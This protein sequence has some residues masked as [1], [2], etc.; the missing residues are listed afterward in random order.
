MFSGTFL[1]LLGGGAAFQFRDPAPRL[2][3]KQII[4][5]LTKLTDGLFTEDHVDQPVRG[6]GRYRISWP[7][8]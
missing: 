3:P 2:P 8:S 1:G 5:G 4:N 7:S 6:R